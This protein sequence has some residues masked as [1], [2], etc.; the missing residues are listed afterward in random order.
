MIILQN[1]TRF[2]TSGCALPI[3][4]SEGLC[5]ASLRDTL[6]SQNCQAT[7]TDAVLVAATN[8]AITTTVIVSYLNQLNPSPE[9][10]QNI[11][12]FLCLYLFGLCGDG[13]EVIQP[14]IDQ[15][16]DLQFRTCA[17]EWT[18]AVAFG[19]DLPD[20]KLLPMEQNISCL[21]SKEE[22]RECTFIDTPK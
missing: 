7:N 5:F 18:L 17:T 10:S 19:I 15:C 14:T 13:G 11:L 20:C 3:Q 9:C 16:E 8:E 1:L 22:S 6:T 21:S 12:Q 2:N 4:Y